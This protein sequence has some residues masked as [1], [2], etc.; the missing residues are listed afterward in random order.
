MNIRELK[1]R[2]LP[3]QGF[4][5]PADDG[6]DLGGEVITVSDADP[7]GA[8]GPDEDRGDNFEP[9]G[10]AK[11]AAAP[12]APANDAPSGDGEDGAA[13]GEDAPTGTGKPGGTIPYA[14]FS[15][16]NQ[17][18]KLALER[19]EAAERE[20][21]EL[22]AAQTAAPKPAATPA[23][24]P[25]PEFD[26]AAAEKEYANAL[27]DGD[28]EKAGKIRADINRHVRQEAARQAQAELRAA[29]EAKALKAVSDQAIKDYPYLDT[30]DGEEALDLILAAR[31]KRIQ[32]GMSPADALAEAV[33]AIAPKF[34]PEG[35]TNN[36]ETPSR[37]LPKPTPHKDTRTAE[38]I[39]RGAKASTAQ[40]P[41]VQAGIGNRASAAMVDVS[42]MT[43][44]Q[45]DALSPA[46]KAKLRG[47]N[48]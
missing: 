13:E 10:T 24:P 33:K 14:R 43:D 46:E 39:A 15:E 6:D 38:A 27:M 28:I 45:F 37:E 40:P 34:A 11:P 16:V 1:R 23:T 44:E 9:A 48:F 8:P 32:R 2:L 7:D 36:S 26:E 35:S 20:L 25:A 4:H 19:A 12:T 3:Y 41:V 18:R 5:R 31:D 22:R 47:D 30:K 29:D 17:E 21:Q 42:Q